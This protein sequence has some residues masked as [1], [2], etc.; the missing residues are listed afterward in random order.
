MSQRL[1]IEIGLDKSAAVS[2]AARLRE[3]MRQV[4]AGISADAKAAAAD[5]VRHATQAR[6]V[7]GRF[8]KGYAAEA[9]KAYAEV[10]AAGQQSFGSVATAASATLNVAQFVARQIA[11]LATAMDKVGQKSREMTREFTSQRD[12]TRALAAVEGADPNNA[13]TLSIHEF[14]KRNAMSFDEALNFRGDFA[15]NAQQYKDR[16]ISD[17]EYKQYQE[18]SARQ[19]VRSLASAESSAAFASSFLS[20]DLTKFGENAAEEAFRRQFEVAQIY[21][22]GKGSATENFSAFNALKSAL[23]SDDALAG[24]F[25]TDAELATI[26]SIANAAG[27]ERQRDQVNDLVRN[28]RRVDNE[29]LNDLKS[30]AGVTNDMGTRATIEKLTPLL[31]EEAKAKGLGMDQVIGGY[32]PDVG[33]RE[34]LSNQVKLGVLGG[35]YAQRDAVLAASNAPGAGQAALDTFMG[36]EVA[37]TRVADA[38]VVMAQAERG[39]E[40]SKLDIVRK[41]ALARLHRDRRIDTDATVLRDFIAGKASWGAVGDANQ[42]RIDDEVQKLVDARSGESAPWTLGITPLSR[43]AELRDRMTAMEARGIDPAK[44]NPEAEAKIDT[45]TGLFIKDETIF[46]GASSVLK[47]LG[48]IADNT[49][50]SQ[51]PPRP[52]LTAPPVPTR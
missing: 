20:D 50:P 4:S 41:Q 47:F 26:G 25:K 35:G 5:E 29:R 3:E 13:F 18:L 30:R 33:A 34:A 24:A 38:D 22:A 42:V 23:R 7:K 28:L 44:E 48:I 37:Q 6:D 45:R 32:I 2:A 11:E 36:T 49:K 10:G 14:A 52:L 31:V 1:E 21:D 8:I 16:N 43:E 15:N 17:A 27:P 51:A 46:D 40:N 19:M 12:K 39:A 9:K